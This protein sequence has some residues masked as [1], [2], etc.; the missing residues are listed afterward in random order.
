MKIV[1]IRLKAHIR[2]K[3]EKKTYEYKASSSTY[4]PILPDFNDKFQHVAKDIE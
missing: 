4:G 2:K 3:W 1:T